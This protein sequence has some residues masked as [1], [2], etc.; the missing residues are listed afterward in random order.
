MA[1]PSFLD[2]NGHLDQ[3]E[4]ANPVDGFPDEPALLLGEAVV[5]C[6]QVDAGVV[7]ALPSDIHPGL[8]QALEELL[9]RQAA[10]LLQGTIDPAE[11]VDVALA[12]VVP[13]QLPALGLALPAVQEG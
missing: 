9:Q 4:E 7:V 3:L 5:L 2:V 6:P 11:R 8:A 1:R 12:H 10:A 13:F